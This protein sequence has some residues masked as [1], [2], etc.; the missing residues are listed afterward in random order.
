MIEKR[1][2]RT[3]IKNKKHQAGNKPQRHTEKNTHGQP[4]AELKARLAQLGLN[5]IALGEIAI[6]IFQELDRK[7][8]KPGQVGLLFHEAKRALVAAL[9]A[10]DDPEDWNRA[11]RGAAGLG[12]RAGGRA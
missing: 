5:P 7:H 2:S 10:S 9:F 4:N 11:A 12:L 3:R 1:R 8:R 6:P